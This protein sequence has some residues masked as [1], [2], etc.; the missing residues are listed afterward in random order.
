MSSAAL[1][2]R[3]SSRV[4]VRT[5]PILRNSIRMSSTNSYGQGK[6]HATG[7]SAVPGKIQEQAPS[8]LE[9][10]LPDS[11]HPTGGKADQSTS[12]THAKDG[13]DASIV[14]KKIQE[15]LPESVERAVPNA[16]HDTGD[17]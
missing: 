10:A 15:I 13:G 17:K 7:E 14:P 4:I 5:S 12:Q 9:E 6:S 2:F 16:I 1:K 8:A 11:V 3:A